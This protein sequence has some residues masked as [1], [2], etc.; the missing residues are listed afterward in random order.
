MG[1]LNS[2][3]A[4]GP[5]LGDDLAGLVLGVSGAG[6]GPDRPFIEFAPGG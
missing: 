5:G 1:N 6:T 3:A 4:T 2:D